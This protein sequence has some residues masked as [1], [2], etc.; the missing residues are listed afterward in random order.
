MLELPISRSQKVWKS[1]S[2]TV[3][4]PGCWI[5]STYTHFWWFLSYTVEID[6]T[7][8]YYCGELRVEEIYWEIPHEG[9]LK[10]LSQVEKSIENVSE[11]W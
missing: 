3:W 10:D 5:Q 11:S 7:R 8:D 4:V 9:W 6:E 2:E 1:I